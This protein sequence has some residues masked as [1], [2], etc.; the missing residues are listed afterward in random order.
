MPL[1]I[2]SLEFHFHRYSICMTSLSLPQIHTIMSR[3]PSIPKG[4]RDFLP[5]QV[6]KRN[7][8]F[9]TIREVFVTYGFAPIETPAMEELHT[10]TGKYGEEGDQLLF[11]VLNNGDYLKKADAA[12]LEA[13]DSQALTS[14]ISKRGLRYDLTIPFARYVVM[15]QNDISFPF[16]RYQIQPVW[17]ADRPQKGRYQE[18][19]QCDV[20]VV[21]SDSLMYEAE[22]VMIYDEVFTKL[23]VSV[24]IRIN[25]RKILYGIAEV[26]G[27]TERFME[28]TVALDKLD[29]I[30]K[31]GVAKEMQ[32]R[33]ISPEGIDEIFKI[34]DD[35]SLE[36]IR[37]AF[38]AHN[39]ETGMNGIQELDEVYSFLE[40]YEIRNKLTF[41][42]T[43]A[44]GLS[45]YTG[46][47]FEVVVNTEI[48]DGI[49]MGSIGGGG[50]YADLTSTF[51]M[52]DMSGVGVSFGAERIYDVMEELDAFPEEATKN[53]HALILAFNEA[54]HKYGFKLVQQLR[55]AGI[56]ADCYPSAAKF[57][58]QMKYANDR[59]IPYCIVI[60]DEEMNNGL[61]TLK[62]MSTGEQ[63]T[64]G[65]DDIIKQLTS[66]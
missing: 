18:F 19:Y 61:Y 59:K 52:K 26:A 12:A 51:G 20:D 54:N 13:K 64:L 21:G 23:G 3:K 14:S 10:L 33:G 48:H 30:G 47:I 43:L 17:R 7:Y 9:D 38:S 31:D 65:M 41:D 1:K 2:G 36:S 57:K 27:C 58:K 63:E 55:S 35:T 16:K 24:D 6:Y 56:I 22:L 40:G 45:Y 15:Y 60:G 25:N 5:E 62:N 29:K 34:L 8:I 50:R 11:K 28:M 46:C 39:A 32:E 66:K 4:T 53:V 37:A 49:K 42:S 44:R